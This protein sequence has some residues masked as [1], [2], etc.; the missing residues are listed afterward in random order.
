MILIHRIPY[1]LHDLDH[2]LY[3][4]SNFQHPH[5]WI[6]HTFFHEKR[7]LKQGCPLSPLLFVIVMEGLN[8]L[9][10]SVKTDGRLHGLKMSNLCF[11]THLLF[12]DDVLIF[13]DGNIQ[14]SATFADI[15]FMFSRAMN[16]DANHGKSYISPSHTSPHELRF[17]RQHFPYSMLPLEQGLKYLG[18]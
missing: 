14:Y 7:G 6:Y 5:K 9:I 1:F 12:V 4:L 15:L 10:A 11:L 3:L 13:L 18:F 8:R 2:V 17:S 16:M